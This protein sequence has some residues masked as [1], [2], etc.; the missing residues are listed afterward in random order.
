MQRLCSWR[1]KASCLTTI[2]LAYVTHATVDNT[3]N[4][5]QMYCLNCDIIELFSSVNR[6]RCEAHMFVQLHF[7]QIFCTCNIFEVCK[8]NRTKIIHMKSNRRQNLLNQ[9]HSSNQFFKSI[10]V[11]VCVYWVWQVCWEHSISAEFLM[12]HNEFLV[13]NNIPNAIISCC[14][15]I[16]DYSHK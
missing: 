11:S 1:H 8:Q 13:K 4:D 12:A 2:F 5:L 16:F 9:Y 7:K 14:T 15:V 6:I 3:A 10:A